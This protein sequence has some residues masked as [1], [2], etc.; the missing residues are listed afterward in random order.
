MRLTSGDE[1]GDVHVTSVKHKLPRSRAV[2]LA[3]SIF[4][5]LST[6]FIRVI[7]FLIY[8]K[9]EVNEAGNSEHALVTCDPS[10]ARNKT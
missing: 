3:T 9:F 8:L 4:S 1:K 10:C 2:F 5:S 7:D 6:Y